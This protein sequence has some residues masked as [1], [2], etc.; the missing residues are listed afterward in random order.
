M[1]MSTVKVI[2]ALAMTSKVTA[3]HG[4][5]LNAN[6]KADKNL[7]L[8]IYLQVPKSMDVE[9]KTLKSLGARRNNDLVLQLQKSV[10]GLKQAGCLWSQL[11]HARL[12]KAGFEKY[13][14]DMCLYRNKDGEDVVVV[15]VYVDD[16]IS[17]STN[18]VAV[19]NLFACLC[20]LSVKDLGR[21]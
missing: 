16:L 18:V 6:I 4:F 3:K 8:D 7:H 1:D 10:Y 5:N 21:V 9:Y 19:D 17:T 14:A 13:F 2:L 20:S 11:L 12:T 15:G